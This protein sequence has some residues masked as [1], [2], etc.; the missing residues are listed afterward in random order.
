MSA[1]H[2]AKTFRDILDGSEPWG[3]D[4]LGLSDWLEER[5][6]KAADGVNEQRQRR[7]LAA[8]LSDADGFEL[9]TECTITDT[10]PPWVAISQTKSCVP[11]KD[12][13]RAAELTA[14]LHTTS[15]LAFYFQLYNK[16]DDL[17][18]PLFAY[19]YEQV[20]DQTE[21][22]LT[23][24]IEK[25]QCDDHHLLKLSRPSD[26]NAFRDEMRLH[27][28]ASAIEHVVS[29][30]HQSK[31][32]KTGLFASIEERCTATLRS[33]LDEGV[34]S[35]ANFWR[36]S[37]QLVQGVADLHRTGIMHNFIHVSGEPPLPWDA[38]LTRADARSLRP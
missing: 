32:R 20:I 16:S 6:V 4:P 31:L 2:H 15:G 14:F 26:A 9:L 33:K 1:I 25:R 18:S 7:Q 3:L 11:L 22:S 17:F 19:E 13:V 30:H 35:D 34:V 28:K 21:D 23:L 37:T 27:A 24:L 12:A 29:T 10:H 38:C 8:Q 5:W 36:W